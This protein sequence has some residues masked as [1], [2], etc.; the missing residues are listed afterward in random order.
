MREDNTTKN[1]N[2]GAAQM[3][4]DATF[5]DFNIQNVNYHATCVE[6]DM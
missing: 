5:T 6:I 4:S 3:N 2:I 1:E